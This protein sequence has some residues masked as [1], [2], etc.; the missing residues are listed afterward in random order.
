MSI[1]CNIIEDS[2]STDGKRIT[3]FCL[4]YPRMIHAE[5]LTH[6]VFSRNASSSRAIPI[7]K[8]I[9][10][11]LDDIVYPIHFGANQPGMQASA[12]LDKEAIEKAKVIWEDMAMYCAEGVSKLN[13]LGLHK[14][15][16]NR[17]LEW[18]S[19]ITVLVTSTEWDNFFSLRAHP[20]AQPEIQE[21]AVKIQELYTTSTPKVLHPGQWHLP[22]VS[23]AERNDQFFKLPANV[24]MLQKISAARCCRVSYLRHDGSLP[25]ID[26]DLALFQRLAGAEPIHASPLE[27]QA[28]PDTYTPGLGYDNPSEHGNFNGWIQMRKIFESSKIDPVKYAKYQIKAIHR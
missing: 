28:T 15:W 23:E 4:T 1:K 10:M 21:L 11:A 20:D 26:D 13:E 6:R 12:E 25:N 24:F 3:T 22:Y 18:F 16:S 17:P 2:I 9:D 27:H 14:Q 8:M 19:N 5:L 7:K